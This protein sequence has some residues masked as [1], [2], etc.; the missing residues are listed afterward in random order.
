MDLHDRTEIT[1]FCTEFPKVLSQAQ[2]KVLLD[3]LAQE[4]AGME[5][6]LKLVDACCE[7]PDWKPSKGAPDSSTKAET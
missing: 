3:G 2:A 4:Y 6:W 5:D 7:H 1:V